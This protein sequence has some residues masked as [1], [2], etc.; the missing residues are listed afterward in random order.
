MSTTKLSFAQANIQYCKAATI[1]VNNLSLGSQHF[2]MFI[3]EPYLKKNLVSGLDTRRFNIISHLGQE[4]IRTCIL[5]SNQCSI[6]PLRHLCTGD[7]TVAILTYYIKGS[8]RKMLVAS[9]Y[10]PYSKTVLLPGQDIIN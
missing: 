2:V 8:E 4:K 7:L 6:L 5:A 1:E 3:Q 10:M 9:A